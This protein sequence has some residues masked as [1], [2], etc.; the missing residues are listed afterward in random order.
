MGQVEQGWVA[1]RMSDSAWV[2]LC[3]ISRSASIAI[4]VILALPYSANA[5][6]WENKAS[7][8][9]GEIYTDNVELDDD[10]KESKF[11]SVVRPTIELEGR[12]RR[13]EM[14]LMAAFEF[15]NVGGAADSFN[16]RI[17]GDGAV[18]LLEDFFF[19]E[20]DIYSNQTLIDPFAAS[21]STQL[22][23][24]DNVTTTY[25]YSISPYAVHRFAR[26]ADLQVR[27]T[28]DD[29]INK[30]DE[31]SDSVQR[32]S[33]M[34]LNS[35]PD[36]GPLS[37]TLRADH[38]KTEFDGDGFMNQDGDNERSTASI[39]VGYELS[40]K[41]QVNSTVGQEWNNFQTFDDDDTDG[42]FWDVGLIWT[43]N[44]RTTFDVGY[45]KHFF[46]DTP[47]FKFT[48]TTRRTSLTVNYSRSVSDTR[49][50]R[51]SAS[52]FPTE[53]A[54]GDQIDPITG[55]PLFLTDNFTFRDQGV[56]VNELFDASLTLKGKR[57]DLT[58][59]VRESKQLREDI[60]S[61]AKFTSTG[62]RFNRQLSSKISVNSRLSL[63]ERESRATSE[64]ETTRFYL[65]LDRQLGPKTS[66]GL[67]YSF[68]DRDAGGFQ[69]S[70]K[71]NRVSLSLT[72]DF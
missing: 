9:F 45:G 40:R 11:I 51:R 23:R 22:N 60:D 59:F 58:F 4:A 37:W 64:A 7:I 62:I 49:S 10:N 53:D 47:R 15:N 6:V 46:G 16:P 71:E 72:I 48:H 55:E 26:F 68:S 52:L 42:R 57:S 38:Q 8:T 17:R 5:G 65:S 12:G 24:S 63:D 39:K 36:F 14:S 2:S 44:R 3:K 70:Y 43:P 30:G 20:G 25:D 41:W 54:F 56:F 67:A 34:T 61:D 13:A 69:Q 28:Y 1:A 19:I 33:V 32:M 66:L 27:Y 29:Q 21:G 18:E 50:E 35:G 31:L